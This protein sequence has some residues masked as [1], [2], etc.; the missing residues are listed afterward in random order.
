MRGTEHARGR[1]RWI[2]TR[3]DLHTKI[4]VRKPRKPTRPSAEDRLRVGQGIG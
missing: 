2:Y 4:R 1:H 3:M